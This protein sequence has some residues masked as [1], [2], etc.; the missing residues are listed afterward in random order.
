MKQTKTSVT[1]KYVGASLIVK[2]YYIK[3]RIREFS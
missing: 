1:F 3:Q 2:F